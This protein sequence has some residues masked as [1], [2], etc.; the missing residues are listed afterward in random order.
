MK[1]SLDFVITLNLTF[2]S[3]ATWN[4]SSNDHI[5]AAKNLCCEAAS[6]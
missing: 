5:P 1:H 4:D 2:L 6:P 3:T